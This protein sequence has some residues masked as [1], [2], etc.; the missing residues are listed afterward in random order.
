MQIIHTTTAP[1]P[2]SYRPDDSREVSSNGDPSSTSRQFRRVP[3]VNDWEKIY[4]LP[5]H[6]STI[7]ARPAEE[8]PR[9]VVD[10][11]RRVRRFEEEAPQSQRSRSLHGGERPL[12]A[13]SIATTSSSVNRE[14]LERMRRSTQASPAP[15]SYERARRYV[16]PPLP[17][18]YRV[19]VLYVS[20]IA[21][22]LSFK[23]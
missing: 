13:T 4:D 8:W 5:P 23:H 1:S 16:P 18:G 22:V 19:S 15:P 17:S 12:S 11:R 9:N 20:L 6:S 7:T 21:L 3:I 10:V 14:S 2:L